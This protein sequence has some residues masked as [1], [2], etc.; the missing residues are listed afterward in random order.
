MKSL[1]VAVSLSVAVLPTVALG[2]APAPRELPPIPVTP[3]LPATPMP[4]TA[5]PAADDVRYSPQVAEFLGST[6]DTWLSVST[7]GW[8]FSL[9]GN[10][11]ARG[12]Q[13]P[14]DLPMIDKIDE[15]SNSA[16]A[17]QFH[18]EAGVGNI[19]VIFDAMMFSEEPLNGLYRAE[20]DST[21]IELLGLYRL[22]CTKA[23][24]ETRGCLTL[25]FLAG[26]RYYHVTNSVSL[27]F[28]GFPF[29]Q[30]AQWCDLVI[31]ARA[32]VQV[33]DGLTA[34]VRADAGGFTIGHS[35]QRAWNVIAGVDYRL[36]MIP[37]TIVSAGYRVMQIDQ[38]I[39]AGNAAFVYDVKLSGPFLAV[40]VQF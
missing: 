22:L 25:D 33:H 21:I 27:P 38:R 34:Y 39:G 1:L 5:K 13:L 9:S 4:P 36:P 12:R 18:V 17:A 14:I 28:V 26:L 37:N 6:D 7:Y 31:G 24:R 8:V 10:L 16:A 35:S 2:Q 15:L 20:N 19:G 3:P 40:G 30:T 32:S 29:E 11:G 23:G